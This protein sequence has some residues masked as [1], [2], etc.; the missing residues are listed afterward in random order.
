MLRR[1]T[2]IEFHR[3]A[4][5]GKTNPAFAICEDEHGA[6]VEV[7]AKFSGNCERGVTSLSMEV[8]AA[9]LAADLGLPIP[10]PYLLNVSQEWAQLIPD[11]QQRLKITSSNPVAF[12][13][14]M[15]T[16][17]YADWTSGTKISDPMVPTAAAIMF[18]DGTI[19]NPDR[20][21]E[22]P[23]CLTR[24]SEI[25]I[26][27]HEL[28]FSQDLVIGWIPPWV[29]GGM[30]TLENP[31]GLH[32]FRDGLRNRQIDFEPIRAAWLSVT[33][34]R[35]DAYGNAIPIE[36]NDARTD[37]QSAIDLIRDIRNN[38]D[39]CITE[40]TRVLS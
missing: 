38:V 20:R 16:G 7:V 32:I 1:L 29:L 10:E 23:N 24:G 27:D 17:Q 22:N 35:L 13:S 14:H 2:P 21:V 3:F 34:D 18:F 5:V 28:T 37:V 8:I 26:Y 39:A 4:K 6:T 40:L 36:W 31:L 30:R 25:R 12:G 19:Q 11:A 15:L 9:C 33:D